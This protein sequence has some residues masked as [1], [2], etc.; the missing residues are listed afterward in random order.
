M[1]TEENIP[2]RVE[3]NN[4]IEEPNTSLIINLED[5]YKLKHQK[6]RELEYY[7]KQLEKLHEKMGYLRNEIQLTE[8]ILSMIKN[9]KVMDLTETIKKK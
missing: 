7:Q 6:E 9:E 2:Q 5:V 4:I 8:T 1:D 3:E